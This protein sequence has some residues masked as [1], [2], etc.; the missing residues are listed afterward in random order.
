MSGID[1]ASL[2]GGTIIDIG[3]R[4]TG[5][6][7][8]LSAPAVPCQQNAQ[9]FTDGEISLMDHDLH[10]GQSRWYASV[11]RTGT[12]NPGDTVTISPT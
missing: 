3:S 10:P 8:Q 11:L 12:I 7:L 2:H 5:V 6:R 4:D 1:W 9:W